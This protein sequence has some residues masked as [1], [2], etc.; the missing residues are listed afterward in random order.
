[1][2]KDEIVVKEFQGNLIRLV[3][4]KDLNLT[5]MWKAS[6][7]SLNYNPNNWIRKEGNNFINTVA[8]KLNTTVSRILKT[9]PGRNGGT[10]AHWQIGL[11][12]AK[13]LSPELHMFVNEIFRERLQEEADPDLALDHGIDRAVRGY[14]R[15][16][17]SEAWIE[18]RLRAKTSNV[19]L[20]NTFKRHSV[21]SFGIPI[22]IDSLQ[23]PIFKMKTADKKKSLGLPPNSPYLRDNLSE[24]ELAS[25]IWAETSA[26]NKI[27][28]VEAQGLGD[29]QKICANVGEA[30]AQAIEM[31]A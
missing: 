29:C 4:G 15:N 22:C 28:K 11:A 10:W 7:K 27:K 14:K 24:L 19:A 23:K 18:L 21:F 30:M 8:I 31:T 2:N 20:K 12:Y 1:M 6:K 16:G 13:Y 26:N 9:Q 3:D 25:I 17:K 5:D